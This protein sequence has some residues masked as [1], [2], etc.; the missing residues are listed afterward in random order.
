MGI[1]VVEEETFKGLGGELVPFEG[2]T[3]VLSINPLAAQGKV[4]PLVSIPFGKDKKLD[5]VM[6]RLKA[7]G[8]LM[9]ASYEGY[10]EEVTRLLME[11]DA[12]RIQRVKETSRSK[13]AARVSHRGSRELKNLCS[14]INNEGSSVRST[15]YL[16]KGL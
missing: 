14:S 6:G 16:G 2:D 5:W 9:G 1:K 11:I 3:E 7:F 10:E 15:V 4:D 13:K 12:R 8:K